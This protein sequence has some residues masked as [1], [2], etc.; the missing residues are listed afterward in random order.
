MRTQI[1]PLLRRWM[2]RETELAARVVETPE[3]F[4]HIWDDPE[5]GDYGHLFGEATKFIAEVETA[6]GSMNR[7]VAE[8][9][10]LLSRW[11]RT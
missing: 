8:A 6:A 1:S 7:I 4:I 5:S 11:S 10:Q 9:E 2:G 3:Q